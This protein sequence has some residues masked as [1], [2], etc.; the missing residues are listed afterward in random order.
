VAQ[1]ICFVQIASSAYRPHDSRGSRRHLVL[2]TEVYRVSMLL[3]LL[4]CAVGRMLK[5]CGHAV[6]VLYYL[7]YMC[8]K[9]FMFLCVLYLTM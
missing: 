4:S 8:F 7:T 6:R 5:F 1:I 3:W 9:K 2:Y